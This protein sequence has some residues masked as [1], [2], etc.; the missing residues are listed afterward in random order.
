MK[1]RRDFLKQGALASAGFML[2]GLN[3]SAKS[4]SRIV[5]ANDRD[6]EKS[7]YL[8]L[9]RLVLYGTGDLASEMGAFV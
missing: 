3:M 6:H 5:G 1:T 9:Y 4:Y 7:K 8:I 2:G